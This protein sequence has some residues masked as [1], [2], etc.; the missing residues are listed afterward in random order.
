MIKNKLYFYFAKPERNEIALL[1]N[2][3]F[4]VGHRNGRRN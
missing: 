1:A 2:F 3:R 4:R